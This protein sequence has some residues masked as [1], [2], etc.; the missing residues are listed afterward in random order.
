ME[1]LEA[2]LE[3]GMQS[4]SVQQMPCDPLSLLKDLLVNYNMYALSL[5]S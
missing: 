3:M 1:V 5:L 2:K 4:A